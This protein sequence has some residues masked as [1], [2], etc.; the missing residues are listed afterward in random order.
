MTQTMLSTILVSYYN[1]ILSLVVITTKKSN[2]ILSD[3]ASRQHIRGKKITGKKKKKK[4]KKQ[5]IL[6]RHIEM[7][8]KK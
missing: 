6:A 7:A 2:Y 1:H 4:K 5:K 3:V 8:D